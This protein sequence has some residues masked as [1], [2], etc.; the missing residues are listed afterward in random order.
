MHGRRRNCKPTT[1]EIF[2]CT[3]HAVDEIA[4]GKARERRGREHLPTFEVVLA[5]AVGT[6]VVRP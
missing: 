2:L 3:G 6:E 4:A 1:L 5:G